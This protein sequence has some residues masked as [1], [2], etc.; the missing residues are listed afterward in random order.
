MFFF[1]Q[2]L[3]SVIFQPH[4]FCYLWN[5]RLV[6]L[7]GASDALI[8]LAYFTIPL[9]LVRFARKRRDLPF[10]WIFWL[11][12]VFVVACGATHAMEVW[13]LWH[14]QYWLAGTI[15]GLTAAASLP[16]AMLLANLVPK[17][18]EMPSSAQ[19][20]DANAALQKEINDRRVL[21][22]KLRANEARYREIAELLNLTHDA[23]FARNLKNEIVYW[24]KGAEELYG[25]K[26]EETRGRTSHSLLNPVSPEPQEAIE[27]EI[28]AT[29]SW[30]GEMKHQ[31]RDGSEVFVSSRWSLRRDSDGNP[32]LILESNRDI[33]QRRNEELKFRNLLEA[34]PD[35]MVIVDTR[36]VIRL[37]NTQAEALFGF[38][39]SEIIGQPVEILMPGQ[40]HE[41][42][43]NFRTAYTESP[44]V[45]KMGERKELRG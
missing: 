38:P 24:N 40:F 13:N 8:A 26:S 11:F 28:F 37:V 36:G 31:R 23:I 30:Q 44:H 43:R 34:A 16:T 7:N 27:A 41:L 17:A 25:W 39:R 19:W 42:H 1:G 18:L 21:E 3:T 4:G 33:T 5:S 6:W 22:V 9:S 20:I 12:G 10:R 15:K 32:Q 35:A 45:R 29:G 2:I 14:A